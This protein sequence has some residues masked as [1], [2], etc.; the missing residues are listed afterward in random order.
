MSDINYSMTV[1][2]GKIGR[3][4]NNNLCPHVPSSCFLST[5]VEE[6]DV[7]Y[8]NFV[9]SCDSNFDKCTVTME[10]SNSEPFNTPRYTHTRTQ[11]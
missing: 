10:Q 2:I 8:L 4:D 11:T 5:G 3:K 7:C 1:F 9:P 6:K